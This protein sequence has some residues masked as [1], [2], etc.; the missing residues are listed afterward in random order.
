MISATLDS[1][2]VPAF[3]VDF[4]VYHEL[5]HKKH[6]VRWQNGRRA[7]HTPAFRAEER[8]FHKYAEADEWIGRLAKRYA[9]WAG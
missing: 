1:V 3:V 9:A 6:G 2:E 5:L 8:C 4:V 7:V